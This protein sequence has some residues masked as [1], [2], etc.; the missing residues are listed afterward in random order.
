MMTPAMRDALAALKGR[1]DPKPSLGEPKFCPICGGLGSS[2]LP[3][4]NGRP[5]AACPTCKGLE[6]HRV[7]WLALH[8]HSKLLERPGRV[9][10]VSPEGFLRNRLRDLPGV[11][12]TSVDLY[13]DDV[14]VKADLCALP[15]DDGAFDHVVCCHVLEHIP[16]D[17]R[18]MAEIARVLR[19]DGQAII[20][21]PLKW[22][23]PTDEDPDAPEAE[24]IRRFGQADHLRY[25][26]PDVEGRLR[27]SGFRR[28][29]VA[30]PAH[31]LPPA[32]VR[33]LKINDE[34]VFLCQPNPN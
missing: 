3:G 9:L 28:V 30:C 16:D 26:G 19:P 25:Y 14:D 21:V 8:E 7:M 24:R 2:W 32:L 17:R 1:P 4:P 11:S 10:H 5:N 29:T 23:R 22:N 34:P 12:Y 6:R 13:R 15:F 20:N 18:A 33:I 31:N 27:G